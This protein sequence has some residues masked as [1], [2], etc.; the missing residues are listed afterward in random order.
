MGKVTFLQVSEEESLGKCR[1]EHPGGREPAHA[2]PQSGEKL[3]SKSD[4]PGPGIWGPLLQ[5][6]L[7]PGQ[8][9][10]PVN[11]IQRNYKGLK[12]TAHKQQKEIQ[13]DQKPN[14]QSELLRARGAYYAGCLHTAPPREW[15]DH[16]SYLPAQ[17]MDPPHPPPHPIEGTCS[18]PLK[19]QARKPVTCFCSPAAAWVSLKPCLNFSSGLLSISVD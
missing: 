18:L 2:K 15:A 12:I 11:R 14:C 8:K 19:E 6:L 3:C 17:L 5:C 9:S 7:A 10:P 16:P 1:E 4:S 13:K